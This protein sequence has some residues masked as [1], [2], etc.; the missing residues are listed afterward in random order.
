VPGSASDG[1][2]GDFGEGTFLRDAAFR[3]SF[4]DDVDARGSTF[5]VDRGDPDERGAVLGGAD[6]K[7][8]ICSTVRRPSRPF[9]HD[10]IVR[11]AYCGAAAD[12]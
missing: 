12:G 1:R 2:A 8:A 10:R 7:K 9:P 6:V 11:S 3:R 5:L 4:P